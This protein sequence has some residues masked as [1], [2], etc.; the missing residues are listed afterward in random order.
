MISLAGHRFRKNKF[1]MTCKVGHKTVN[2][3][4]VSINQQKIVTSLTGK[5]MVYPWQI[6]VVNTVDKMGIT[7]ILRG[8]TYITVV[9]YL[10]ACR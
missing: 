6:K 7:L 3:D 5:I 1:R 2:Q 4:G 10:G 9:F 8:L